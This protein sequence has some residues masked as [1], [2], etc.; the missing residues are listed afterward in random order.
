ME[1]LLLMMTKRLVTTNCKSSIRR[2]FACIGDCL[3]NVLV[4]WNLIP[5][6][7]VIF[8]FTI[9]TPFPFSLAR[10]SVENL[11]I[12]HVEKFS[13][14]DLGRLFFYCFVMAIYVFW[15]GEFRGFRVNECSTYF[16]IH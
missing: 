5:H 12:F 2:F 4:W 15:V 8:N 14:K 11:D 16:Y 13:F 1:P 3:Y 10:A 7:L 9:L 6:V